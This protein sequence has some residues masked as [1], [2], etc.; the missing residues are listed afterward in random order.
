M[1]NNAPLFR[2]NTENY[3]SSNYKIVSSSIDQ[4][5]DS[6]EE[7]YFDDEEDFKYLKTPKRKFFIHD[8]NSQSLYSVEDDFPS[9][10]YLDSYE[11]K[12]VFKKFKLQHPSIQSSDMTRQQNYTLAT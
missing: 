3:S 9:R 10:P 11:M 6:K 2:A 5:I 1:T 8:P 4:L 7:D 12:M